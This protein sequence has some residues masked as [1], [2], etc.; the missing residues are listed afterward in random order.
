ME[1]LKID[2][3]EYWRKLAK[4]HAETIDK[5][6]WFSF[7]ISITILVLTFLNIKEIDILGIKIPL[8]WAWLPLTIFTIIHLIFTVQFE[9]VTRKYWYFTQ[10]KE[11]FGLFKEITAEGGYFMRGMKPRNIPLSGDYAPIKSEVSVWLS[12]IA[13]IILFFAILRTVKFNTNHQVLVWTARV[14][15]FFLTIAN[16]VIGL[17]WAIVLSELAIEKK[18]SIILAQKHKGILPPMIDDE[19]NNAD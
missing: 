10:P 2:D 3:R 17:R 5:I 11:Y 4:A 19:E 16:W 8:N 15:P 18:Y 14:L 12:H 9:T 7:L 13:A 6:L 1:Q